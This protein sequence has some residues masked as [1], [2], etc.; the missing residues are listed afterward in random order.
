MSDHELED[1]T[2]IL[3]FSTTGSPMIVLI[4]NDLMVNDNVLDEI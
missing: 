1:N 3:T 4:I 2:N